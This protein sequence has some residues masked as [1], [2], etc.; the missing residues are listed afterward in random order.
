MCSTL[1]IQYCIYFDYKRQSDHSFK[2]KENQKLARERGDL[3]KS[4]YLIDA[5]AV[6]KFFP[7]ETHLSEEFLV[8]GGDEKCVGLLANVTAVHTQAQQLLL[9]LQQALP[10]PQLQMLLT[11]LT[12]I[13]QRTVSAQSLT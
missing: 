1:F 10:A 4:A 13:S 2:D 7:E 12:V 9:G 6:Q 3:S 8:Q 11:E 5:E